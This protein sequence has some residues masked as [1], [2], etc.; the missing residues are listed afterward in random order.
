MHRDFNSMSSLKR[1][2]Y[3]HFILKRRDGIIC[4]SKNTKKSVQ[5]YVNK[6][7][8]VV[9]NGIDEERFFPRQK[10]S[11]DTKSVKII[12]ASR[13]IASKRV[14]ILLFAFSEFQRSI[15]QNSI[16]TIIGD[17]PEKSK[18]TSLAKSLKCKNVQFLGNIEHNKI[19][20]Y[21]RKSDIFFFFSE[22]EGFGVSTIEAYY[23][24]LNIVASDIDIHFELGEKE[25]NFFAL[26]DKKSLIETLT[27]VAKIK[28]QGAYQNNL[29]VFS[30]CYTTSQLVAIYND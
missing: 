8:Y 3:V 19:A 17:G 16:L 4:N 22:T 7:L 24:G 15:T 27:D 5:K 25:F 12:T 2:V 29:K 6:N 9:Y 13:L 18:L 10:K 14:D 21:L 20:D 1:F 23:C 30:L 11:I 26:N 28:C